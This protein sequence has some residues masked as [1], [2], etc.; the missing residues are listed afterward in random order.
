MILK[1][2]SKAK[3]YLETV[4][5]SQKGLLPCKKK[6]SWALTKNPRSIIKII[7]VPTCGVCKAAIHHSFALIPKKT[8]DNVSVV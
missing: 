5:G 6:K 4:C 1:K 3:E 7:T 8:L 2:N